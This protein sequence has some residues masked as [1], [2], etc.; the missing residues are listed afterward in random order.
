MHCQGGARAPP[1]KRSG[2]GT[3]RWPSARARS[4][5]SL[6]LVVDASGIALDVTAG[7]QYV[8]G[9]LPARMFRAGFARRGLAPQVLTRAV[10]DSGT[11]TATA[12]LMRA[13]AGG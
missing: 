1:P 9:V 13:N 10:E 12:A 4:R 3:A 2:T 6:I 5:G 7:D 11:V 8:A